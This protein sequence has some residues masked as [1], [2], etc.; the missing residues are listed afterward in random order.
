[1]KKA[2]SASLRVGFGRGGKEGFT[3][4]LPARS[5]P[6]SHPRPYTKNSNNTRLP[7]QLSSPCEWEE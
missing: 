5:T 2:H 1:N 6:P 3:L 7:K 4:F